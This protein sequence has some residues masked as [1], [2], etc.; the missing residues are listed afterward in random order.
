MPDG[1]AYA[2]KSRLFAKNLFGGEKSCQYINICVIT[3]N[4][5]VLKCCQVFFR[6]KD[7]YPAIKCKDG[8]LIEMKALRKT[9]KNAAGKSYEAAKMTETRG[10]LPPDSQMFIPMSTTVG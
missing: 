6:K 4:E 9:P 5:A 10:C 7:A 3:E 1:D 8:A 2:G